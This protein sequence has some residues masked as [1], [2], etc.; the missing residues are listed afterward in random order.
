[1]FIFLEYD[2]ARALAHH[3]TVAVLVIGTARLFGGVVAAHVERARL[4]EARD[5]D[6]AD[7]RF[8]PAREHDVGV[9]VLDHRRRLA[10]RMRAGRTGGDDGMFWAHE[11]AFGTDLPRDAGDEAA[12]DV[13]RADAPRPLFGEQTAFALDP[14]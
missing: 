11:A 8:G 9:A 13:V 12:V 14:R 5:A 2:D 4:R 3:E 7:R 1:M 10:A 6:R